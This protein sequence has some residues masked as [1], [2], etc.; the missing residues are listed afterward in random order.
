MTSLSGIEAMVDELSQDTE[1]FS[2]LD[3]EVEKLTEPLHGRMNL[4]PELFD[5][6]L[7]DTLSGKACEPL[8]EQRKP[9]K[10]EIVVNVFDVPTASGHT[11]LV[12]Q[13]EDG[14]LWQLCDAGLGWSPHK[15]VES[16]WPKAR[17]FIDLLPAK[18]N[19]RPKGG[20]H[21]LLTPRILTPER[22]QKRLIYS[23]SKAVK[24]PR[25]TSWSYWSWPRSP[26]IDMTGPVNGQFVE[27]RTRRRS[28]VPYGVVYDGRRRSAMGSEVAA[29]FVAPRAQHISHDHE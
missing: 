11:V 18:I 1:L 10:E 15:A 19:P 6:A 3:T 22:T 7:A 8:I 14:L 4:T 12:F 27:S 25:R 29:S 24:S 20:L 23:R 17:K 2:E 28:V 16:S 21:H 5:K 13:T 9:K 26:R